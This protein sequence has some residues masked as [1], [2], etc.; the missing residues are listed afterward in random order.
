M[1]KK[2]LALF[3]LTALLAPAFAQDD[4]PT[5]GEMAESSDPAEAQ[6]AAKFPRGAIPTPVEEI[7]AAAPFIPQAQAS[8][9]FAVVPAH[10]Q[11]WGN[12]RY[13]ICVTAEEAFAKLAY[14]K[15]CG[16]DEIRISDSDCIAWARRHGVLNGA[17]LLDV[18]QMAAKDGLPANGKLYTT[19]VPHRVNFRDEDELRAAIATGPVKVGIQ[20]GDLP[21]GAGSKNGWWSIRSVPGGR[22]DHAVALCGYGPASYLFGELGLPVPEGL[23]ADRQGYLLFTWSTIGFVSHEFIMGS[24]DEMWVRVPTTVGEEPKPPPPPPV[25]PAPEPKPYPWWTWVAL[26]AAGVCIAVLLGIGYAIAHPKAK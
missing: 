14:S 15:M 8:A 11:Y 2:L 13:G 22:E 26:I 1:F 20:A 25:P 10:L 18:M 19:G 4:A 16:D 6:E 24:C 9:Q 3:L 21:R 7:N 5:L 12:D 23:P 17:N